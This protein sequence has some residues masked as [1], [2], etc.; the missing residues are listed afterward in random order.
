M[1]TWSILLISTV[2]FLTALPLLGEETEGDTL[3]EQEVT[4]REQMTSIE[5]S[6]MQ[7]ESRLDQLSEADREILEVEEEEQALSGLSLLYQLSANLL[8]QE[9]QGLETAELRTFVI[10]RMDAVPEIILRA[11]DRYQSNLKR[12]QGEK[13]SAGVGELGIIEEE[14]GAVEHSIDQLFATAIRHVEER[15]NL[16]METAAFSKSIDEAL[17]LR[18]RLM[19]GRLKKQLASRNMLRNRSAANPEDTDLALRLGAVQVSIETAAESLESMI[20][21]MEE[22]NMNTTAFKTILIQSTG[23]ISRGLEVSVIWQFIQTG[24][25]NL[26]QWSDEELPGIITKTFIFFIVLILFHFLAKAL[27]SAIT[28]T[29]A[30]SRVRVSRLLGTMIAKTSYRVMIFL[31]LMV[32]LTQIGFSLTPL[33]AGLGVLGFIVGFALQDTLGNFASG[34]MILFYRPFDESDFVEVGGGV[35]GRVNKMSLVSTTILTIDNQTL[36]VPNSKIWG[37][38]ICNLTD[39]DTRRVDLVFG[40]SYDSEIPKVERVIKEVLDAHDEIL[41]EPEAMIR[42]HELGDSS[43]NFVVRPWVKTEDYW[44]TFWS[45]TREIKIR[46]DEEGITIPFPQRDVHHYYPESGKADPR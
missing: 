22:R 4:L 5:A 7:L 33:L 42:V 14:I 24:W 10:A 3:K 30:S 6:M 43:V 46:F 21:F 26:G 41:P 29:V 44:E 11:L 45:L 31:G 18:A 2:A 36:V 13:E 23:D 8:E 19:A 32:G 34:L 40:V 17:Q 28:R 38:V 37:D 25:E 27:Q 9:K 20:R 16:G 35:R 1:K 12:L 39:Q 15:K